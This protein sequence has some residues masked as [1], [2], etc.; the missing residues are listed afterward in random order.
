M[1]IV[2]RDAETREGRK[3]RAVRSNAYQ[4]LTVWF[5]GIQAGSKNNRGI[6]AAFGSGLRTLRR[7]ASS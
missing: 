6:C 3:K 1:R 2:L 5:E 4:Y 7:P